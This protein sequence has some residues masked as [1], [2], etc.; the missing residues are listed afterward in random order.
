MAEPKKR[1]TKP[2]EVR[3]GQ[4]WRNNDTRARHRDFTVLAVEV[5]LGPDDKPHKVARVRYEGNGKTGSIRCSRLLTISHSR[6]F[7]Y[8]GRGDT[9]TTD[10]EG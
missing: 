8:R 1:P 4:R 6:G 3:P 7:T 9:T 10:K 2:P 5:E